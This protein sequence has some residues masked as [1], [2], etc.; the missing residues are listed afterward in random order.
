[1]DCNTPGFLVH[2][3]HPELAQTHVHWV[4]NDPAHPMISSCVVPFF[5]NLSS[6]PASWSF[7]MSQFFTSGGQRIRVSASASVFPVNI[8]DWSFR[9]IGLISLQ[10]K[11][12][13]ES[14]TPQFKS[15]NSSALSFSL[16]S[17]SHILHD[18]SKNHNFDYM[19]LCWQNNVSAF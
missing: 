10:S 17:N 4:G 3:Q 18:Y 5:S 1:M 15:I 19:D 2:H 12:P 6:F 13:Q 9:L 16:W 7:R 8:W 14:S 11:G